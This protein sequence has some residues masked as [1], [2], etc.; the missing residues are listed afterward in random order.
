[1]KRILLLS[2]INSAH[3][4]K[5]A[6]AVANAGFETG[7]FSLSA[8]VSD[9]YTQLGIQL[10]ASDGFGKKHFYSPDIL[11]ARDFFSAGKVR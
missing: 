2:D 5:W 11:K 1:M 9:W 8:P 4:Q 10:L 7:I 6:G 3:T